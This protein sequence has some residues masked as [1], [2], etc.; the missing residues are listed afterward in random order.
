MEDYS[1]RGHAGQT[2]IRKE[3]IVTLLRA[4]RNDGDTEVGQTYEM[5]YVY[6]SG[7]EMSRMQES[8]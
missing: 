7:G 5:H 4:A 8:F 1:R 6:S 2:Q 3:R